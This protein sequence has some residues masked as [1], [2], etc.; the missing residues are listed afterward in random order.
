MPSYPACNAAAAFMAEVRLA[1]TERTARFKGNNYLAP[2]QQRA[3]TDAV[4]G[5][6]LVAAVKE[7]AHV[8]M[9]VNSYGANNRSATSTS[10]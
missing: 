4:S 6:G 5:S 7:A 1:Q 2:E 3:I 10:V 8:D 9:P